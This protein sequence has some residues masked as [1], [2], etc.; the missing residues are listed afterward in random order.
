MAD[1]DLRP[2]GNINSGGA[3][4]FYTPGVEGRKEE[5]ASWAA[6]FASKG[7]CS[8]LTMDPDALTPI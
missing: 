3:L 5:G 4:A 7:L 6:N 8:P 2:E 1:G